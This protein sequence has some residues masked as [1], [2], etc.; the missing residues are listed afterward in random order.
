M[1]T[2]TFIL[3]GLLICNLLPAQ[4]V[5]LDIKPHFL[6]VRADSLLL[7]MDVSVEIEDMNPKNAVILTPVLTGQD[8]R[9]LLPAIQLNGK[10]KQKLYLRNQILRKKKG[11]KADDAAYLVAGIDDSHSRT[12]NYRTALPA[13]NWMNDATLYLRRTI[14]RPEGEQTLKDTLIIAPQYAVL[15]PEMGNTAIQEV[16]SA[17]TADNST[18]PS[19][20]PTGKK[21][22]Y[23]GSYV[24]PSSDDVDIRNQKELNFNLEEAKIMADINPQ[25][26]SL[27]ELYTVALSYADNKAKFYQIINISVKL[28]PV[29]PVA[30][31]N[32]A[33]AAIE[34]G[35]TK[36]ASKFLSMALHEG[37]AYKSCR[38]V[39]E[40]MTGNT[41]EGIRILKAAKAEGSEEAAY[42]LN[43]FFENNKRH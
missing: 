21:P 15:P 1:K 25:M 5:K 24:S 29:H 17:A 3:L 11:S 8:H 9:I 6:G 4:N 26:L 20:A 14:V 28:Y 12:I 7:S 37:L 27:R 36:S 22:R 34:Q 41:Y 40:L 32:A 31:L 19:A 2:K 16:S 39:Y 43:V 33:A 18:T 10:Q 30:N 38:G 23:K 35:D 42:N 13:E